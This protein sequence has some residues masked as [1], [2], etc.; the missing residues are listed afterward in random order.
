MIKVIFELIFLIIKLIVLIISSYKFIRSDMNEIKTL[1]YGI[2][3]LIM[4]S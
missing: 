1:Y 4:L 2:W 3:V